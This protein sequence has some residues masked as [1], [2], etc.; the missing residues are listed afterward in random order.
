MLDSLQKE[1]SAWVAQYSAELS[2]LLASLG[3]LEESCELFRAAVKLQA[4]EVRGT[5]VRYSRADLLRMLADAVG[6]CAI[7]C[8]SRCTAHGVVFSTAVRHAGMPPKAE[9]FLTACWRVL[10][11]AQGAVDASDDRLAVVWVLSALQDA[12]RSVGLDFEQCVS[13]AWSVVRARRP[14]RL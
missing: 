10:E 2:P 12:V 11:A 13:D 9:L 5:E 3:I 4:L 8:C 7:Y 1:H 6:D 14:D